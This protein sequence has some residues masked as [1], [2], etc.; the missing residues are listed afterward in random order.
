L[1]LMNP[2]EKPAHDTDVTAAIRELLAKLSSFSMPAFICR[3]S[4][5]HRSDSFA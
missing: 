5:F 1:M 2:Y 4:V 3:Q